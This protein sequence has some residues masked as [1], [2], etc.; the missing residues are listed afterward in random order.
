MKKSMIMLFTI[1]LVLSIAGTA[2]AANDFSDVAARHWAY[3]AV[4]QLQQAGL[5]DGYSDGTFRGDKALTR[6]EFAVVIARGLE[7]Y[8]KANTQQKGLLDKLSAEFAAELNNI[9]VRLNKLEKNQP[10]LKFSGNAEVRYTSQDN[11]G[12]AASSVGGAYRIRL[13]GVVKV[14][15]NTNLGLRLASGTTKAGTKYKYSSATFSSFGSNAAADDNKNNVTLDRIFLTNNIGA[16][17]TTVGAQELKLGTT[18]FIVDSGATSFDGVKFAT[19][20]GAVKLVGN[21]GRQ[22][23]NSNTTIEVASLEA[24]AKQGNFNYGAGYATLKD[25]GTVHTTLAEYLY[26]NAKYQFDA[27]FSLGGEYVYNQQ[28]DSDKTA[29]TAIATIGDQE[30]VKKGQNNVVVKYYRV[31]KNSISRLT[32]YSLQSKAGAGVTEAFSDVRNLKGLNVAY[33][34]GFSKNLTA[35]VAY[36]KL[37]DREAAAADD[38]G[39]RYYRAAVVAKF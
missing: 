8:T 17:Q 16:V 29:W 27:G 13:N 14:D 23:K 3:D 6:Y 37:T 11:N 38:R 18:N 10:N 31:G 34:Y 32:S 19:A 30:I 5:V 1:I 12:T 9:G 7:N 36:Q 15:D 39:F 35:Y 22:Q 33:N 21:W 4:S 26:G 20:A 24:A 28:S 2:V 25:R